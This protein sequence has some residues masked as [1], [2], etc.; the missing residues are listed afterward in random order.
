MVS[1]YTL[2]KLP[3]IKELKLISNSIAMLDA[4]V[5]PEGNLDI[6]LD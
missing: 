3:T 5:I 1:I 4:I 6:I 2:Q